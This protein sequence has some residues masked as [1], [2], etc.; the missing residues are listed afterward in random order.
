MMSEQDTT[1]TDAAAQSK[2][3]VRFIRHSFGKQ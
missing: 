1:P 3:G 2:N